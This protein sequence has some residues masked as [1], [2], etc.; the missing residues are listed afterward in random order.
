MISTSPHSC[1]AK[2]KKL[3]SI[4]SE[5]VDRALH[6]TDVGKRSVGQ[7]LALVPT[8]TSH[9]DVLPPLRA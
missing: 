4:T 6:K 9:S 7:S 5:S 8:F 3:K 2:P 1:A